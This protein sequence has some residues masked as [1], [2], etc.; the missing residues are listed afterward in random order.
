VHWE[1]HSVLFSGKSITSKLISQQL[2][3][4]KLE[5]GWS[6]QVLREDYKRYRHAIICP[7]WIMAIWESL[8]ACKASVD[9]KSKWIPNPARLGDILIMEA[10]TA[11]P[12]V[13]VSNLQV[14][15]RCHIYL[16]VFF[17]SDII[18]VKGDIIEEW[19]LNGE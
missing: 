17:L 2:D 11:S 14:I 9:I 16:R 19:A 1:I 8:Y 4:T 18:N 13:N 3:Y 15:N 10:L 7:N 12:L 6:S 5:I